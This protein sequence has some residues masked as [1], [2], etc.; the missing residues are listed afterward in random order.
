[1][2]RLCAVA[3]DCAIGEHICSAKWKRADLLYNEPMEKR[4]WPMGAGSKIKK[5]RKLRRMTQ[6]ELAERVGST[7]AA[8]RNY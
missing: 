3:L 5:L 2:E 1:M 6:A 4:G 7:D 8:I